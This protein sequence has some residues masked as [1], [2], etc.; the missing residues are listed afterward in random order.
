V[1]SRPQKEKKM[2]TLRI[3]NR[4]TLFP[5]QELPQPTLDVLKNRLSFTNPAWLENQKQGH[6]NWRVPQELRFWGEV[7]NTLVI[8][9]GFI[10]WTIWIL[11][12]A[13]VQFQ[14]ENQT[15]RLPGVDFRFT[16]QLKNFQEEALAA[17]LRRDF[18][19]LS[20]P[21]GSGKTVMALAVIAERR[22]PSLIVVHN[23]ELL[24]QWIDRIG[25]F[26][27]LSADQ[28]GVI[29]DGRQT[30]G[31][32]V[33][34]G[35]VQTLCKCAHEIAPHVGFLIADECHRCPSRTFTEAVTA[36]DSKFMLGLSATPWRRDG[37][38]RLIYWFLGDKVHEVEREGLIE[39]GHI[40]EAEVII[41]ETDFD[42]FS[43]PS[44]EY[45]RMLSELTQDSKRN[46]LIAGDVVKEAGNGG[47]V[48]LVLTDRKAHCEVLAGVLAE[49]G[50]QA[51]VLT[52]DLKTREREEV[53][54]NLNTGQVKVLVATGQLIGEGFDCPELSTLFLA[55]P[56]R[57]SGRVLQYLGRV[58]RPAPGK[59]KAR[60]YDYV[61]AQVG[62]LV[63]AARA[64]A[65]AYGLSDREHQ[66]S[67]FG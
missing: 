3:D 45:S 5:L 56:I 20:A 29:G 37:L 32:A 19:T 39:D 18:G 30:I 36:F 67:L 21:T 50:V 46:A 8:P 43:D 48:C 55:T 28:V 31:Q 53:V 35:M 64:R 27:G 16:G 2:V 6:S 14:V 60:V 23:K 9:R 49:R 47:S 58:L 59:D 44:E 15:R 40:L 41:R 10:R 54:A 12:D 66:G 25:V 51:V 42:P 4:I 26:L 65:R 11:R 57:F 13:G 63:N 22:Q 38:S 1:D 17:V 62:V 33:T 7:G 24:N 34:V 52:G 61:D